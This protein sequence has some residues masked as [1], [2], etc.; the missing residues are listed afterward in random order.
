MPSYVYRVD[1]PV[2]H[3]SQSLRGTTVDSSMFVNSAEKRM[4]DGREPTG[5]I[6]IVPMLRDDY[7]SIFREH[8][9]GDAP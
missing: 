8:F 3:I 2:M 6:S 9:P 5:E 4:N 7:E 1:A